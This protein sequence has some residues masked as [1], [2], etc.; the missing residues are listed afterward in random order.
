MFR[1]VEECK[2]LH[3]C[4]LVSQLALSVEVAFQDQYCILVWAYSLGAPEVMSLPLSTHSHTQ[5]QIHT[6][7][8]TELPQCALESPSGVFWGIS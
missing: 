5:A 1:E 4:L 8:H 2:C 6:R 3:H 7:T